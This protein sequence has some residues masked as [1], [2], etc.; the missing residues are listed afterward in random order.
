MNERISSGVYSLISWFEGHCWR[1]CQSVLYEEVVQTSIHSLNQGGDQLRK[2]RQ[3][4]PPW[5]CN[6][7]QR[8]TSDIIG[9]NRS[10]SLQNWIFNN[11]WVLIDRLCFSP[12][13]CAS[14][15]LDN[16][17]WP[18]EKNFKHSKH[19]SGRLVW[20]GWC[21]RVGWREEDRKKLCRNFKFIFWV[22]C[23]NQKLFQSINT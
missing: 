9:I 22:L 7:S 4:H 5:K 1:H 11:F 16:I 6:R 18:S 13:Y 10:R 19:G 2:M 3:G 8:R 14:W 20:G 12:K 17:F 23:R 15:A 21:E